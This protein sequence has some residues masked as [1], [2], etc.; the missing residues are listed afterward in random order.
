MLE[1]ANRPSE[2]RD[3]F[4]PDAVRDFLIESERRVVWHCNALMKVR[5]LSG[6]VRHRLVLL[7]Q[8][9]EDELRRLGAD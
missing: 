4:L 6:E 5:E 9:A 3:R 2:A 1:L 7:S 8:R